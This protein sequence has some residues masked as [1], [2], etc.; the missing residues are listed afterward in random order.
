MEAQDPS[1]G[2]VFRVFLQTLYTGKKVTNRALLIYYC[3]SSTFLAF[4]NSPHI[5]VK[6]AVNLAI[7]CWLGELFGR[8]LA[9]W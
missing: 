3:R 5:R 6:K 8:D 7:R 4:A 2:A 9:R 1:L